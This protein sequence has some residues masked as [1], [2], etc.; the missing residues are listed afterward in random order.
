MLNLPIFDWNNLDGVI[1]NC[2]ICR[3]LHETL[4]KVRMA[5]LP[6]ERMMEG[7]PFTCCTVDL[8]RF[9]YIEEI[10]SKIK[11]YGVIFTCLASREIHTEVVK[12]RDE[13]L[14]IQSLRRF[15]TQREYLRY[16]RSDN[17]SNFDGADRASTNI[18]RDG[19]PTSGIILEKPQRR[20]VN[21]GEESTCNS[22]VGSV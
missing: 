14:F 16:L 2:V 3:R 5:D 11:Q 18:S 6:A 21:K 12:H 9:I 1:H 10:N 13:N 4:G 22:Y 8:F 7:S 20:L 19:S 15:I 17:D